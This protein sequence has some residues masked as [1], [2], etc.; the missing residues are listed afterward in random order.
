MVIVGVGIILLT[1]GN[2][3][4]STIPYILKIRTLA[5]ARTLLRV[6]GMAL[7]TVIQPAVVQEQT[8]SLISS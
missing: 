2:T 7:N 4:L 8:I 3:T 6:F 1:Y 5:F